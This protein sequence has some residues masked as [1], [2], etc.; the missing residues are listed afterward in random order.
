MGRKTQPQKKGGVSPG[1]R[2]E[3]SIR[4]LWPVRDIGCEVTGKNA[5][6]HHNWR[7]DQ[8]TQ[9]AEKAVMA[10]QM[11]TAIIV[12]ARGEFARLALALISKPFVL[13]IMVAEVLPGLA[14]LV[15]AIHAR[16]SPCELEG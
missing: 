15:L 9:T 5:V 16:P 11:G 7:H 13:V 10:I 4:A 1:L 3:L 6:E 14:H 2:G 8:I 12:G